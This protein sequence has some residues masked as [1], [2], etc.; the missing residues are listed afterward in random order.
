LHPTPGAPNLRFIGRLF[1]LA[2]KGFHGKV[3]YST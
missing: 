3:F 1:H 2:E